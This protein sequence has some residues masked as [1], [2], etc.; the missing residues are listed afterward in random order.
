MNHGEESKTTEPQTTKKKKLEVCQG[1]DCFG[2]GGGAVLL[3][4]E[5][6]CQEERRCAVEVVRGACRN[7]CSMGPNVHYYHFDTSTCRHD[8]SFSQVKSIAHCRQVMERVV[9]A[10]EEDEEETTKQLAQPLSTVTRV[11]TQ[12]AER[13]RWNFLR[14]VAKVKRSKEQHRR[15]EPLLMQL[16]EIA[17]IEAKIVAKDAVADKMERVLRRKQRYQ[18]F[19]SLDNGNGNNDNADSSES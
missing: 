3:E 7:F 14:N 5:E 17:A 4:L 15:I 10:A 6:L 16:E 2:C 19:L 12:Q 11:M 1:P 18:Q 9:A 8:D 13:E